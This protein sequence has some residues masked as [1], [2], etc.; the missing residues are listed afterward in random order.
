MV[1]GSFIPNPKSESWTN[2]DPQPTVSTA[3]VGPDDP[4]ST[5]E[6]FV[7]FRPTTKN[8]YCQ[9][10]IKKKKDKK[11]KKP[12]S[13][14]KKNKNK[15]NNNKNN[16]NN[17]DN[18]RPITVN[19]RP[20]IRNIIGFSPR[21]YVNVVSRPKS[22]LNIVSRPQNS[23]NVVNRPSIRNMMHVDQEVTPS[24]VNKILREYN[25]RI[26][27]LKSYVDAFCDEQWGEEMDE[28]EQDILHPRSGPVPPKNDK[29]NNT[30]NNNNKV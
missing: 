8:G 30:N 14:N 1:E 23:V 9:V 16:N 25:N 22:F 29:R 7:Q 19:L 15:S 5:K 27:F 18:N 12:N 21:N 13:N 17:N 28:F 10:D 11:R 26:E 24:E 6:A 20:K 3:S 4:Q 2:P